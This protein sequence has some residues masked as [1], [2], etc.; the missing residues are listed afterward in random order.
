MSHVACFS[1]TAEVVTFIFLIYM[2]WSPVKVDG[3]AVAAEALTGIQ[4]FGHKMTR[5]QGVSHS[6]LQLHQQISQGE[7]SHFS[8]HWAIDWKPT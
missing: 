6:G 5:C 8:L 1:G 2:L 4:M 3:S 7:V